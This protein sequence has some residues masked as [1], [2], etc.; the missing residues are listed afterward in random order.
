MTVM[1]ADL[2]W[3]RALAGPEFRRADTLRDERGD[4][5]GKKLERWERDLPGWLPVRSEPA[6]R[7]AALTAAIAALPLRE[8]SEESLVRQ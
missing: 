3:L 5:S 4:E 6:S 2:R 7:I 8:A 1:T